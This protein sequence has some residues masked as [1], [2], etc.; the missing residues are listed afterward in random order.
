MA[1]SSAWS[2][3]PALGAGVSPPALSAHEALPRL[4]SAHE[5]AAAA[6]SAQEA[7]AQLA[8]L[9][10]AEAQLAADHD[11]AAQDA[12]AQEAAAHE[13]SS[14]ALAAQIA[15][16]KP[17]VP[18]VGS[19]TMKASSARFGFGGFWISIDRA[20]LTSPVPSD[21]PAACG[22]GFVPTISAPLTWSG[23]YSGCRPTMSEATPLTI[24][25][26][27]DVPESSM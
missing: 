20:A 3:S 13:A 16:S 18:L 7:E 4:R 24:G 22:I 2:I 12:S 17:G 15:A 6:V 26:E 1:A 21:R 11:A 14:F 5:A 8:E 9:Q 25:A 19:L 27:K 10:E 23:V